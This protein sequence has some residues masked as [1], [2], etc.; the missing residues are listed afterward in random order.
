M[1]F[2][3]WVEQVIVLNV[4]ESSNREHIIVRFVEYVL[5]EWITIVHGLGIVLV[6]IT[7][8]LSFNFCLAHQ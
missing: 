6:S 4:K 1:K 5:L 2:K 3:L 7:I 8:S